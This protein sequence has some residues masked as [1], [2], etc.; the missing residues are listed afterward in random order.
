LWRIDRF[1]SA[2]L[3]K[4]QFVPHQITDTGNMRNE[5]AAKALIVAICRYLTS[6]TSCG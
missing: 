5:R 3:L 1:L 6:R 4:H 2:V